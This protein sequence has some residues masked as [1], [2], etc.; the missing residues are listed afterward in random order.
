M[1]RRNELKDFGSEFE[2]LVLRVDKAFLAG[3]DEVPIGFTDHKVAYTLRFRVYDYFKA[4]QKSRARPDLTVM[5]TNWSMRIAGTTLVF[6]RRGE[7]Q[8]AAALRDALGLEK[9]FADGP[10]SHGVLESATPLT[11]HL[12]HLASIRAARGNKP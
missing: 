2:Q 8:A 4:L 6:Y 5:V 11:E 7:D 1:P 3:A 9:G 10:S 12:A